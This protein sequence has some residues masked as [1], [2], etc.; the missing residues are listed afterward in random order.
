MAKVKSARK[1][2]RL[3][4]RKAG[5]S[6][7]YGDPIVIANM[8]RKAG[9]EHPMNGQPGYRPVPDVPVTNARKRRKK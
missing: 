2:A 6:A 4:L 9:K 3:F 5:I 8:V 1:A 7:V